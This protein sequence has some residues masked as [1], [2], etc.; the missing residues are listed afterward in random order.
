MN[1]PEIYQ[2]QFPARACPLWDG[3]SLYGSDGANPDYV[4]SSPP[5]LNSPFSAPDLAA[6][7]P[8]NILKTRSAMYPCAFPGCST[9]A[10]AASLQAAAAAGASPPMPITKNHPEIALPPYAPVVGGGNFAIGLD[11]PKFR[12]WLRAKQ[13]TV[14]GSVSGAGAA[15]VFSGSQDHDLFGTGSTED[16]I[17]RYLEDNGTLL[18]DA[19]ANNTILTPSGGTTL[20]S[21]SVIL[22]SP[23]SYA[24]DSFSINDDS[25]D[26]YNFAFCLDRA[27]QINDPTVLKRWY[28]ALRCSLFVAY[29]IASSSSIGGS[30]PFQYLLVALDTAQSLE[31]KY[32]FIGT[33]NLDIPIT[34]FSVNVDGETLPLN[35]IASVI[36]ITDTLTIVAGVETIVTTITATPASLND[37]TFTPTQFMD[38]DGSFDPTTGVF[39]PP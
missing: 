28:P 33:T 3:V 19:G 18:L 10:I 22:F 36:T 13:W 7:S 38:Y 29:Q 12:R 35:G 34:A 32:T 20:S 6:Q 37:I 17:E 26:I 5:A 4:L 25:G 27:R 15:V 2:F 14:S 11:A 9:A 30:P 21:Q 39:N 24:R 8:G 31:G 16:Q 1:A 23:F